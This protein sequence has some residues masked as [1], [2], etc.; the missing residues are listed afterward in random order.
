MASLGSVRKWESARQVRTAMRKHN[1]HLPKGWRVRLL[2]RKQMGESSI[3]SSR[4]LTAYTTKRGRQHEI[5]LSPRVSME[6]IAHEV[7]H[8]NLGHGNSNYRN[9]KDF[10][11]REMRAWHEV[12]RSLH[13]EHLRVRDT[14]RAIAIAAVMHFGMTPQGAVDVIAEEGI[15]LGKEPLTTAELKQAVKVLTEDASDLIKEK[16]KKA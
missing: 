12:G 1:L 3:V 14:L 7:A 5:V 2:T 4:L 8:A 13:R 6:Q 16:Q 9:G 11:Q 15:R 10:I